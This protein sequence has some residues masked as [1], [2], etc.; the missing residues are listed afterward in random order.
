MR[1]SKGI[2]QSRVIM[3]QLVLPGDTN[4]LGSIF[5][6]TIMSW[7]DIC[8]AIAAG[9]HCQKQVVTASIDSLSFVAPVYLGWIV[10]LKASVNYVARTSME[11]G[12]RVDAENVK[13]GEFFHTSSAY[14]TFVC[15]SPEGV[16]EEVPELVL[17]TEDD[18]R[19]YAQAKDRRE[20]RLAAK[21]RTRA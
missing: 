5:G 20:Q 2:S 8:A 21:S 13:T 7:I 1:A 12:V 6:G 3:T 4:S 10:N 15:I 16:P 14:L 11:V 19:R 18:R 17:E 9:R